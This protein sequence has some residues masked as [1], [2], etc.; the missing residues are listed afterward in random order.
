MQE[1]DGPKFKSVKAIVN[2][3]GLGIGLQ[4]TRVPVLTERI[5]MLH[6]PTFVRT[7]TG[8]RRMWIPRLAHGTRT[9]WDGA[10]Q[11]PCIDAG[12]LHLPRSLRGWSCEQGVPV[13]S[14][15]HGATLYRPV[16]SSRH[17]KAEEKL[18]AR[19]QLLSDRIAIGYTFL[20]PI[21]ASNIQCEG[22]AV[23]IGYCLRRITGILETHK[24]CDCASCIS[25][26]QSLE[27]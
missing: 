22:I 18:E 11:D 12:A 15:T 26:I 4:G 8:H 1:Q 2:P 16:K 5:S 24:P 3:T 19:L 23:E 25:D 10:R 6:Q 20:L 14:V 21:F 27:L 7:C 13:G 9:G 17:V